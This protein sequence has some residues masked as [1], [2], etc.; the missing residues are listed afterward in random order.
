M[1]FARPI[2]FF[3]LPLIKIKVMF[4]ILKMIV[5]NII[6]IREMIVMTLIYIVLSF[7]EVVTCLINGSIIY[8]DTLK[9]IQSSTLMHV[10]ENK[11]L[12]NSADK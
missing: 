8:S 9:L 6:Q 12:V 2:F 10:N 7:L 3:F 4:V 1:I 5:G 11:S